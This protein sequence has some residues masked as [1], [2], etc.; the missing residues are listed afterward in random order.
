MKIFTQL[1]TLGQEYKTLAVA[2]GTFDGVH[3]GHQ[4]IIR[5]AVQ[6]AHQHSGTSAVFTFSNHPLAIL[7]PN[8]APLTIT[9]QAD[10]VAL[11]EDLGVDILFNIPL[12]AAFLQLSPHEFVHLLEKTLHPSFIVVG[13]NYSFGAGRAGTPAVL[14]RAGKTHH[15]SVE[16]QDA[17]YVDKLLVSSTIIRQLI[18]SG[19]LSQAAR[20]LGRYWNISGC[21]THGD[22]RGHQIGFPT[23]NIAIPTGMV[24]P[25]NGVYAVA[26]T[27]NGV[28]YN[29]IANVG[30][31]PTFSEQERRIEIHIP[32]YYGDLYDEQV[33]AEFIEYIRGEHK[34]SNIQQLVHQISLD[35]EVANRYYI[36][37]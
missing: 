3:I 5:R 20:L 28:K 8:A 9:S 21:V 29:A 15:F 37:E 7:T 33:C 35:I 25:K 19:H 30:D 26:I 1:T 14:E 2:L 22:G 11:M 12:S 13:P 36:K 10:K 17:I 34:F 27:I 31:N 16:I 32:G 6:Y 4:H 24:T 23:A 18:S